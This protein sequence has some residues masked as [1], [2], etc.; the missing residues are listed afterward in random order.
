[1]VSILNKLQI[2][3]FSKR[4]KGNQTKYDFNKHFLPIKLE[5]YDNKK[6]KKIEL[7]KLKKEE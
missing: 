2:F 5:F 3:F 6:N 4:V 7:L 1:M